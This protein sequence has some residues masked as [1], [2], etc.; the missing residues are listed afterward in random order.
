MRLSLWELGLPG[1]LVALVCVILVAALAWAVWRQGVTRWT[2]SLALATNML[3]SPYVMGYH[4]VLLV[5]AFLHIWQRNKRL[6][7]GLW[8]LMFTPLL[9]A[10][11]EAFDRAVLD[12]LYPAALLIALWWGPELRA[13]LDRDIDYSENYDT[14]NFSKQF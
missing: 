10:G 7:V 9:R 4:F 8:L 1:W 12:A 14:K 13:C 11:G 3:I 6:A 5:P 2:F